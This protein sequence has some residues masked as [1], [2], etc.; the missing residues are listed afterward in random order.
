MTLVASFAR[1]RRPRAGAHG[2]APT[3]RSPRAEVIVGDALRDDWKK[4]FQPFAI[5]ARSIVVRP[6]W[7]PYEEKPGERVLVLEPGR[8]FG[9][10]LHETTS[11]VAGALISHPSDVAGARVLDVG[12]GSGILALSRCSSARVTRA[13][14]TRPGRRG[15]HARERRPQRLLDERVL[16]DTTHVRDRRGVVRSRPREHR[17]AGPR[18]P[19]ATLGA[20]APRGLLV[21]S[22]VLAPQK[23]EV[24]AA[25][26]RFTLEARRAQGRV[27]GAG[28]SRRRR[29]G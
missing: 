15:G 6:P 4:H 24:K 9:T 21:L 25:Y 7:Q 17:G 28:A 16:A 27:G 5:S 13:A 11:L 20:R 14:S 29:P 12:C 10:G 19:G 23:D 2:R 1:T 8:A 26:A 3:K 22:G 18:P